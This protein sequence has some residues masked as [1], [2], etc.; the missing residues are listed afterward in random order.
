MLQKGQVVISRH[1]VDKFRNEA[2]LV[3]T[4]EEVVRRELRKLFLR[5]RK[6]KLTPGLIKRIIDNN[7][8]DAA[9]Y[10]KGKWRF[11]ICNNVMVTCERNIFSKPV[12]R[13][14]RG[15]K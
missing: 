12:R 5:S 9:Y 7:F 11:V 15:K 6:E 3:N 1:A 2:N 4:R 8:K 14:R 10:R 13:R